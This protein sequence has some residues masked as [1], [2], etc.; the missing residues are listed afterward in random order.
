MQKN[1]GNGRKTGLL[2]NSALLSILLFALFLFL[3]ACEETSDPALTGKDITGVTLKLGAS[4]SPLEQLEDIPGVRL[5]LDPEKAEAVIIVPRGTPVDTLVLQVQVSAGASL[6]PGNTSLGG[7]IMNYS[8][9]TITVTAEDG[10]TKQWK[11]S[12][13]HDPSP[14]QNLTVQL[15]GAY[16]VR[17]LF[18]YPNY[19]E[20]SGS[21]APDLNPYPLKNT[22]GSYAPILLSYFVDDNDIT[23]DGKAITY[24]NTLVV[25]AGGFE[26]REWK[27][28]GEK[29]PKHEGTESTPPPTPTT[30][31]STT[32]TIHAQDWTLED[33]HTVTFIGTKTDAKGNEQMY[34]GEFTFKVVEK[35]PK[36]AN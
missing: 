16:D 8:G 18:A 24:Y 35:D 1:R 28:D 21:T 13:Q 36:E 34:S 23:K 5:S 22:D 30:N 4:E 10:S 9:E 6:S 25:S 19:K 20:I 3:A 29:A 7:R 11:V 33:L 2:L 12:V 31:N 27:I 14:V 32:L 15:L 17:F 26:T